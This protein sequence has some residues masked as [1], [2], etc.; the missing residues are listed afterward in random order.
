ML[1]ICEWC[2][3]AFEAK[4]KRARFCGDA[5]RKAHNRAVRGG[6]RLSLPDSPPDVEKPRVTEE[7]IAEAV[8]QAKG[9]M[10]VFDSG[11]KIGPKDMRPMCSRIAGGMA[12][13]FGSVGL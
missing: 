2:G 10:A 12:D 13:L 11:S 1:R 9:S 3:R 7:E 5:C 8:V 6:V 4:T